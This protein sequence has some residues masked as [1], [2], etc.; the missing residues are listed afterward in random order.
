MAPRPKV[1]RD[2]RCR[3]HAHAQAVTGRGSTMV[4]GL[5]GATFVP[6][7]AMPHAVVRTS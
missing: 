5:R 6:S 1:L 4:T 2:R 3:G 7:K